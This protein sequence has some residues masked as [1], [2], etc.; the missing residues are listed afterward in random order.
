M[1]VAP[2][3]PALWSEE[4][5][6]ILFVRETGPASAPAIVFVHG[7]GPSGVMWRRHLEALGGTFHCLAPDLPGFGR[8]H[9]LPPISLLETADLVA[10]LIRARIPAGRAHLVGLSYGGSVVFA[11]LARHPEVLDRAVI[12]G[13]G[14]FSSK[15]D[16]LIVLGAKLASPLM[17]RGLARVALRTAGLAGLGESFRSAAPRAIRRAWAEGY[18][19]PLAATQ[20]R[21]PCPTL[22]VA[23]E[24][25]A[26]VRAS[27]AAFAA[28]M[29]SA[30]AVFVPGLGHAWF[31]WR[32]ELHIRMIEAWLSDKPLP[33]GLV[34]E[35]ADEAAVRRMGEMLAC[36][37]DAAR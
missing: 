25:E 13:A 8:S 12:D 1:T 6:R 3:P 26:P 29:P 4:L 14:P 36:H 37:R 20:L 9:R 28:L 16:R 17:G 11:V 19:A 30:A 27:N 21:A 5:A 35:P 2:S 15:S 22:L 32:P 23:G 34:A 7:G 24:R 33:D 31:A 10:E 18:L